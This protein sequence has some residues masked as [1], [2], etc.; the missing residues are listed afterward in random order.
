MIDLKQYHS[1]EH[2]ET[3]KLIFHKLTVWLLQISLW[4][5]KKLR[6]DIYRIVIICSHDLLI[7]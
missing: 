5:W 3:K 7:F 6:F 4:T 1:L 2:A